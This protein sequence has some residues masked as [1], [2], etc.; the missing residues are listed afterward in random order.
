MVSGTFVFTDTMEK[1]IDTLFTDAYTGS[2]AVVSAKDVVDLAAGETSRPTVPAALLDEVKALPQVEAASGAIVDVAR[3][4][5]D[6]GKPISTREGAVGF[7]IEA[8][9]PRFNPL[10]LVE[11]RWPAGSQQIAIDPDTASNGFAVGDTIG[12]A[13]RGPLR[14]FT[15]SG[16]R[17]V[18]ERR[19]GRRVD[20]RDLQT[21]PRRRSSSARP[22][23]ST[24]SSSPRRKASRRSS[25][26]RRSR[27]SCPTAPKSRPARPRL[28]LSPRARTRTSR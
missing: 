14:R 25:S 26:C 22:A 4:I 16:H 27:R 24:R 2:D 23:A 20:T 28:R 17:G 6:S 12:V 8:G 18:H 15:I 21:L 7:S 1:A 5:D 9:Q 19:R 10:R 13:T 11:G 3:L